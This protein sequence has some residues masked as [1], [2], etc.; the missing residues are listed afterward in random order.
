MI[1]PP[2]EVIKRLHD[3]RNEYSLET[4]VTIAARNTITDIRVALESATMLGR[5]GVYMDIPG[6]S[7]LCESSRIT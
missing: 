2:F 5:V 6:G 1:K 7:E 3:I 4:L